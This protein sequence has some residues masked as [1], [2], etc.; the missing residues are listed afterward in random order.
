M[1]T[2]IIVIVLCMSLYRAVLE[3]LPVCS[4]KISAVEQ[5]SLCSDQTSNSC[6]L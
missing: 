4:L 5:M 1:I 2:E 3:N 6:S